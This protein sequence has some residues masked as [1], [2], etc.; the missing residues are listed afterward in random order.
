[1]ID[2][3]QNIFLL[4]NMYIIKQSLDRINKEYQLLRIPHFDV[5]G[6]NVFVCLQ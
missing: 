2:I 3:Q 6:F 4:M 1:M 5:A